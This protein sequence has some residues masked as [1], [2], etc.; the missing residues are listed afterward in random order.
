MNSSEFSA[1]ISADNRTLDLQRATDFQATLLGMAGHDLRQP[2]QVIRSTYALLRT[3]PR[4]DSERAWLENGEQAIVRLTGQLD[5]LLE[6]LRLYEYTK[7]LE[8]TSVALAP[9]FWRLR[10]ENE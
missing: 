8:I 6:A 7:T 2:L 1:T 9:L 4:G 5:R 3:R 10:S